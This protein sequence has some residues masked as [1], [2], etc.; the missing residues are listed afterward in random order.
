MYMIGSVEGLSVEMIPT[1]G[2]CQ[3]FLCT[4]QK[5]FTSIK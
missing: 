4:F 5:A 3:F 2:N 1:D